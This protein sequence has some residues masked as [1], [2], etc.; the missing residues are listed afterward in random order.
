MLP[1]AKQTPA[2]AV[3]LIVMVLDIILFM[4]AQ[5]AGCRDLGKSALYPPL[6]AA[7]KPEN[8]DFRDHT[9]YEPGP[10]RR[11]RAKVS[12]MAHRPL[13]LFS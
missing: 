6:A 1:Y 12:A 3:V 4:S 11:G 7:Y 5:L 8:D 13:F 9:N 2:G 10:L